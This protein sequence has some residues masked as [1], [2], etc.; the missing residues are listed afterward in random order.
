MNTWAVIQDN[1]GISSDMVAL[2]LHRK[3]IGEAI[4]CTIVNTEILY[5]HRQLQARDGHIQ[6]LIKKG[7]HPGH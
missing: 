2:K 1:T 7:V 5:L 4:K 3:C 6:K